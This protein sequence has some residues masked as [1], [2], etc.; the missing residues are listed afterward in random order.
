[1]QYDAASRTYTVSGGG[2]QQAFRAADRQ[3]DRIAGE[4]RYASTNE[5]GSSDFLTLAVLAYATGQPNSYVG[6]GYWQHNRPAATGT[7]ETQ[8]QTFTYGFDTP[9]AAVPR[10]GFASWDTDVFGLYTR[11]GERTR[12]MQGAG[13]LDVD[14][15]NSAFITSGS[16]AEYDVVGSGGNFTLELKGGGS[17][18]SEGGIAG[19]IA[20]AGEG[21]GSL[22][23]GFYGPQAQELGAS[24]IATNGFGSVLNG[25]MTGKRNA[26]T[27][28]LS[29]ITLLNTQVS[30]L[31]GGQIAG[32]TNPIGTPAPGAPVSAP[33]T[34]LTGGVFVAPQGPQRIDFTINGIDSLKLDV[35]QPRT[36]FLRY[37]G[38]STAVSPAPVSVDF[39]RQGAGN[40]ELALT[41]ASFATWRWTTN[42]A[43]GGGTPTTN[44][45]TFYI[46]YGI[47]PPPGFVA[48]M[49][50]TAS[51]RGVV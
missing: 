13:R 37:T 40:T 34:P 5:L 41:Y 32:Q 33:W 23:G 25:A 17:I 9:A 31:L 15:A 14:F 36:N 48:G 18:T 24:F 22:M 10:T 46:V 7:Q 4:A 20:V 19:L 12:T 3:P 35:A 8:F 44:D 45:S 50:G 42:D 26:Q 27:A 6:M 1:M 39:Y 2:R 11:P 16:I 38:S 51:Y 49:T 43:P 21:A 28:P 47:A 30:Q 29:N